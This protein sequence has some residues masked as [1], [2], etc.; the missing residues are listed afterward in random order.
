MLLTGEK[1]GLE[2]GQYSNAL[3]H[4]QKALPVLEDEIKIN[5][6]RF[7]RDRKWYFNVDDKF[8]GTDYILSGK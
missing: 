7:P 1:F 2:L 6:M 8:L 3:A 5:G 4:L